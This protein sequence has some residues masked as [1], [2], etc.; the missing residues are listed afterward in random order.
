MFSPA[1]RCLCLQEKHDMKWELRGIQVADRK[2]K[3]TTLEENKILSSEVNEEESTESSASGKENKGDSTAKNVLI[4]GTILAAASIIAK[5]IG[6]LYRIPLYNILG[7]VGN[8]YYSTANEIYSII[9]MISSFSL[10][11]A[12]SRLM[13]ERIQKGEMRN[14]NR[15]FL[16]SMRFGVLSGG[17]LA[18]LTYALA[19][20]ITKYVMNVEYAKFGLRVLAPVI[21]IFAITGVFRGFFQGFSNMVPTA[22]S[23]V[24]E[25][26][27]NAIVS[28]WGA[29]VLMDYGK[30]L[31]MG[32]EDELVAP[33]WGAAGA[34]FGTV[35]S[36]TVALL[37][38]MYLYLRFNR[39]FRHAMRKD[40]T[41]K[42]E[43]SRY[44]Y[45]VL[46]LTI[47]PIILSTLVYNISNVLDQGI[48]NAILKS[49][50]YTEKQY[51]TIWGIYTGRFRVLMNVP[52]SLASSLGPAVVPTLTAAVA[53]R[54]KKAA[55]KTVHS[56]TRYTMVVTI[57][58]AMGMAALGGPII[59]MLFHPES[60]MALSA[61]IMQ[62]GAAVIILYSLSTLTTAI[63]QGLGKLREPL[64]HNAIALVIHVISL[65][66]MLRFMNLNIY[67]VLYSNAIFALVV[68]IMNALAIRRYIY[69]QQEIR[70]TFIIPFISSIVMAF[71]CYAIWYVLNIVFGNSIA[72]ILSILCGIV[73]YLISMVAFHGLTASEM[74]KLPKGEHLVRIFKKLGLLRE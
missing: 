26:V 65:V 54:D 3:D 1:G 74:R 73:I 14:A 29:W 38:M 17:I 36:V 66:V 16:C 28:I 50:N 43:S 62:A 34:T 8:S 18:L 70:K 10:P 44:L 23:Q 21:L 49:Q 7:D 4:Q 19:G 25:Q 37:F 51:A 53:A 35:A 15:V 52:L 39:R 60:G 48:F 42:R 9:L 33:G 22:I 5:V 40:K 61:G 72:T 41:A 69:Y 58:C 13:S 68:C 30:S 27:V 2:S 67:A 64:I 32:G 11:L 20:V 24:I 56:S 31:V 47:L 45:R 12:V 57:P 55:V 46:I 63:L 6:L 59:Q 71:A